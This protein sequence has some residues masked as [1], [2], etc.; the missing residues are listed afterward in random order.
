MPLF[1]RREYVLG[2]SK[3][4]I[5]AVAVA[6]AGSVA[7][8][9]T[10][11]SGAEPSIQV[12]EVVQALRSLPT[13]MVRRAV[14]EDLPGGAYGGYYGFE[15]S[16]QG[17]HLDGLGFERAI[18][19]SYGYDTNPPSGELVQVVGIYQDADDARG[20]MRSIKSLS[21]H[22]IEPYLTA[23]LERLPARSLGDEFGWGRAVHAKSGQGRPYFRAEF[24]W[25]LGQALVHV[26]YFG[27]QGAATRQAAA[28]AERLD[29][30]LT[31]R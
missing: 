12:S 22:A 5:L 14:P 21:E 24:A 29:T 20:A 30:L 23:P 13:G 15:P 16:G 28:Y 31:S 2:G 6:M 3:L 27:E 19:T 4:G 9:G 7:C 25:R 17:D 1:V 8:G 18:T 11:D 26:S 10:G